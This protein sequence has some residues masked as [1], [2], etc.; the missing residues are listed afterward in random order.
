LLPTVKTK[1][2][3]C[4]AGD[5]H[6]A[7][8]L[9]SCSTVCHLA[10]Y[11]STDS[12]YLPVCLIPALDV[13]AL[14]QQLQDESDTPALISGRMPVPC[15]RESGSKRPVQT[16]S[17]VALIASDASHHRNCCRLAGS[18][19]TT[20]TS[21]THLRQRPTVGQVLCARPRRSFSE[22]RL[23]TIGSIGSISRLCTCQSSHRSTR[24]LG[25]VRSLPG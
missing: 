22:R 13:S 10:E 7:L 24:S 21:S 6:Y 20:P 17:M 23:E 16:Y 9:Y 25:D 8:D 11:S 2:K 12:A 15:S 3:Y 19:R 5:W 18:A 1:Q 14:R 4:L